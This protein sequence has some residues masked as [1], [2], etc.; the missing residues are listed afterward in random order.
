[1]VCATNTSE[2]GSD[3]A[4]FVTAAANNTADAPRTRRNAARGRLEMFDWSTQAEKAKVSS[5]LQ[6]PRFCL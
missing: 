4:D 2:I 1:V 5:L 3:W 6:K